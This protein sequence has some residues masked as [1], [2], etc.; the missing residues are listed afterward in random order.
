M[1]LEAGRYAVRIRG[2]VDRV[3]RDAEGRVY[4]V[5]FKTGKSAPTAAEVA[6][7]PQLAVYQLAS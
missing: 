5:D 6:H 3:E 1:T 4:V 7:H 2:S